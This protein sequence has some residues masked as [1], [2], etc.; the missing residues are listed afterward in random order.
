MK[1]ILVLSF[2]LMVV[3]LAVAPNVQAQNN[4]EPKSIVITG[5]NLPRGQTPTMVYLIN[6]GANPWED[7]DWALYCV[8]DNTVFRN[9]TIT[10]PLWISD[11]KEVGTRF[12]G[13]GKF[14]L[15]VVIG[16]WAGRYMWV[17]RANGGVDLDIRETV[18]TLRWS[19][20]DQ[21]W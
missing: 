6:E 16:D 18:T 11:G 7:P 1:K 4:T 10:I 14:R 5:V 2:A 8:V 9:R 12:T 20:F 13:T 19:D 15:L 3:G 17:D 21:Q